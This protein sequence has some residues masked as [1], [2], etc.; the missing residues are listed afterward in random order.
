MP[1]HRHRFA[2]LEIGGVGF[3]NTE[4][5]IIDEKTRLRVETHNQ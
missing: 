2:S 5:G 1:F 4:L 3:R